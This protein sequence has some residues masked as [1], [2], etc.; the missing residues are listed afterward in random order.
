M[1]TLTTINNSFLVIKLI[2]TND[3]CIGPHF[4]DDA[5]VTTDQ[6]Y[7]F[8]LTYATGKYNLDTWHNL[9]TFTS[10]RSTSASVP[11]MANFKKVAG[12]IRN[13]T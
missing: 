5:E 13:P 8:N 4:S 11:D 10:L 6:S 3:F 12:Q 2:N 9:S 1:K 7:K